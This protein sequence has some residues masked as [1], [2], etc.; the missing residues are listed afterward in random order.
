MRKASLF[1]VMALLTAWAAASGAFAAG[2][3]GPPQSLS[4]KE[5]GLNTAVGFA[6][7]EETF[8]GRVEH[9]MRSRRVFMQA[10]CGASDLWEIYTGIGL[11]D[12]QLSDALTSPSG[13]P[14]TARNDFNDDGQVFGAIGAK[15]FYPVT[16]VFGIGAFAQASY[17]F[18]SYS[19]QI[20]G[21][22]GATRFAAD[23]KIKRLWDLRAGIGFQTTLFDRVRLYGGP[24]VCWAKARA[25]L[26]PPVSGMP[27]GTDADEIKN[28]TRA[29]GFAGVG[30]PLLKGFSL[31]VEGRYADRFSVASAV[32]YTY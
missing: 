14:A 2:L 7:V 17:H 12:L 30:I 6:Y 32:T 10:A 5:G 26:L 25:D 23:L 20:I 16:P 28:K 22:A 4:R 13:A 11:A 24:Y 8:E 18:G 15:A 19:D 3:V 21:F 31:V 1:T 27:L 9:V 29:G